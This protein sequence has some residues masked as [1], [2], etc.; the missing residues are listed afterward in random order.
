MLIRRGLLL[1]WMVAAGPWAAAAFGQTFEID[2]V[3]SSVG[4]R[5]RHLMVSK[6]HGKFEKFKGSFDYDPKASKAWRASVTIE[7]SSIN[8]AIEKRDAHLRS[9]DFLD[10][11]KFPKLEF[12]FKEAR[13]A[14]KDRFQLSGDLTLH[15]VTRPVV[16][17][18]EVGGT[19]KDPWGGTRA[20]F[21]AKG[22][23]NRKD[24]GL[25][26]NEALETGGVLVG[27]EVEIAIEVEGVLKS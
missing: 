18:V 13:K 1:G 27:E 12:K 10:V 25:T 5:V 22:R 24:F 8:T 17:D 14:G 6:V 16:L 11:Q 3:H 23:I 9:E 4:F 19:A 20:G 21:S 15:G 7:A 2:P 26:W